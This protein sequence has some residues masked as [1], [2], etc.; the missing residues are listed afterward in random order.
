M[1]H[2]RRTITFREKYLYWLSKQLLSRVTEER[3]RLA[4]YENDAALTVDSHDRVRSD[5]DQT[6]K[7]R[8]RD[9]RLM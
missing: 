3:F 6:A 9:C 2:V 1:G 8:F 4:V 7:F 5:L